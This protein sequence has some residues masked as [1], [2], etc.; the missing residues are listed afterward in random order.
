MRK[1]M[2]MIE[3]P[4]RKDVVRDVDL[5]IGEEDIKVDEAHGVEYSDKSARDES[6]VN[7]GEEQELL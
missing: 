3:E 2:W 6:R 4:V 1:D 7:D 5:K